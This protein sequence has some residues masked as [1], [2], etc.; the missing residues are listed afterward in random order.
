M[1]GR[2][3]EVFMCKALKKTPPK[4]PKTKQKDLFIF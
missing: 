3:W 2:G 4:N 1:G